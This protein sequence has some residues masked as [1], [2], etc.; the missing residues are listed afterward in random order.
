MIAVRSGHAML[1]TCTNGSTSAI[2]S[3]YAPLAT[4]TGVAITPIRPLR[5]A[6][7]AC[8]APGWTTPSTSTP[9]VVCISRARSAGSAAA[10]AELQAT[11]SSLIRRAMQLLRDLQAERL[12]LRGRPLA[13]REAGRVREVHEVLVR[14]LDQQLVQH[15]EAADAGVEDPD[16]TAA[17]LL[18]RWRGGGHP[19]Q[20]ATRRS[21]TRGRRLRGRRRPG[22][23]CVALRRTAA[24]WG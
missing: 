15:R 14:E 11:T 2:A 5:V 7:T 24:G 16:G 6:A 10:V 9:S 12:Q 22:A 23:W 20:C 13:V 18:G 1:V 19:A 4:V 17:Q 3:A 21:M 8:T